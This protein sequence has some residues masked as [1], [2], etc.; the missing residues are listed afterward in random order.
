[1]IRLAADEDFNRRIVRG[2]R[3]RNAEA[4]ILRAQEAGVGGSADPDV[5]AW[6]AAEGRVLLTH[7]ASTMS[8]PAYGRVAA[9][10]PMPGVLVVPQHMRVGVAIEEI[11]LIVACSAEGEW[12]GQVVY[13]PL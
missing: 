8:G 4:D 5:L 10:L 12:E 2:I 13:L 3:R 11:L 1:M 6:A 7:D 9:G